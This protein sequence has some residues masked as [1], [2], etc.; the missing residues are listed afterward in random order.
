MYYFTYFMIGGRFSAKNCF[1]VKFYQLIYYLALELYFV[2]YKKIKTLK[3]GK[4]RAVRKEHV[5]K[6]HM[7]NVLSVFTGKYR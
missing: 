2:I 3:L 5:L 6:S 7:Y 1:I 4:E